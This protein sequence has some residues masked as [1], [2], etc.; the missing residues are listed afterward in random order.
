MAFHDSSLGYAS[1][2]SLVVYVAYAFFTLSVVLRK[3]FK[4]FYVYLLFYCLIRLGGQLCGVVYASA[5]HNNYQWLI[6]YLILGAEGYLAVVLAA[7]Q[8][9]CRAQMLQVG[10]SWLL[11]GHTLFKGRSWASL[12][13]LMFVP[14]SVLVIVGG[15]TLADAVDQTGLQRE[16]LVSQ[17]RTLRTAGQAIFLGLSVLTVNLNLYV[18]FV[19]RCRNH[20]TLLVLCASPFLIMRGVFGVMS[21]YVSAM[22]YFSITRDIPA[23]AIVYEYVLSILMEL[24]AVGCLL[25]N[26]FCDNEIDGFPL[27]DQTWHEPPSYTMGEKA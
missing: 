21:I 5:G 15:T 20:F 10:R 25:A 4:N 19:E 2:I 24:I 17:S 7:F 27:A 11:D 16:D 26:N 6:A 14:A 18:L 8:T 12:F 9:I 3:G 1:A 23:H 22:N 13:R